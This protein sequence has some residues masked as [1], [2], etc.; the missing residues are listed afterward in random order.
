MAPVATV[1][2]GGRQRR[3]PTP[4]RDKSAGSNLLRRVASIGGST[5]EAGGASY[6]PGQPKR[7][8]RPSGMRTDTTAFRPAQSTAAYRQWRT[9]RIDAQSVIFTTAVMAISTVY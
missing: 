1:P 8:S 6:V 7:P 9:V 4:P 5:R 2:A 3:H